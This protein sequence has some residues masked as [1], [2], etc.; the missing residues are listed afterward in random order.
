M[1]LL[2]MARRHYLW[3]P[4][5]PVGFPI[6]VIGYP[7]LTVWFSVFIA[8]LIKVLVLKYGGVR[9]YLK[10][11]PFFMGMILGYFTPGGF[12]LIIDHFTGMTWNVIFWG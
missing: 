2:M 11:R 8:W 7:V 3:W 10:T 5:H 1:G 6:S 9:L 12:Y 4:L